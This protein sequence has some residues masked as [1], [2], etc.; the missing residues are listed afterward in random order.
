MQFDHAMLKVI[1]NYTNESAI[2]IWSL[3]CIILEIVNGVP[4]WLSFDSEIVTG[5]QNVSD[6]QGLFAV[7]DRNFEAII[8]KQIEVIRDLDDIIDNRVRFEV[9]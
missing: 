8:K 1:K 4:L 9:I 3:G 5:T 7:K 2:D 6:K